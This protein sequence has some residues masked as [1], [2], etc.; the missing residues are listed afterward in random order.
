MTLLPPV[1]ERS[2][3]PYSDNRFSSVINKLSRTITNGTDVILF[4]EE[5]FNTTYSYV[6]GTSSYHILYID[7]GLCIKDDVLVHV[8]EDDYAVDFNDNNFYVDTVP[9][10]D[11]TGWYYLVLYYNY[12]RKFPSPKAYYMI[13]K[14]PAT[15][16]V[17][18]EDAYIFLNAVRVRY[19]STLTRYEIDPST[20]SILDYDPNDPTI[21]REYG[22]N[23]FN[24]SCIDGGVIS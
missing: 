11:T 21:K 18:N 4:P 13:I 19:N 20:G 10:M 5:S 15:Y 3:D 17:G 12:S 14:D 6:D 23:L 1:Q 24:F 8:T 2:V 22:N 7:H 9:G 16:Y